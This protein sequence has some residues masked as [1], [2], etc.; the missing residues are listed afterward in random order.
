MIV[1]EIILRTFKEKRGLKVK[2]I[3]TF[4]RYH[5]L[6]QTKLSIDIWDKVLKY[7]PSKICGRQPLK[8][9]KGYGLLKRT[10]HFK[11]F[12]GC[13]PQILLGPFLNTL[14]C[15]LSRALMANYHELRSCLI[16]EHFKFPSLALSKWVSVLIYTRKSSR[17]AYRQG[18]NY[19]VF[20]V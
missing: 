2:K 8:N 3:Q 13:L 10:N 1:C 12:K 7:R 11:F 14:S 17:V 20:S 18:K 4:R 9:L 19:I 16:S 6:P 5:W 15:I